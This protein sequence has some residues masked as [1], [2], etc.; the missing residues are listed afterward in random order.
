MAYRPGPYIVQDRIDNTSPKSISGHLLLRGEDQPVHLELTG[1]CMPDLRGCTV[2]FEPGEIAKEQ[3][4]RRE[5]TEEE[6]LPTFTEEGF[7]FRQVGTT[8]AITADCWIKVPEVPVEEA[9]KGDGPPGDFPF[10]WHRRF[11]MEWYSQNGRVVLELPDP[12]LAF[13]EGED[14]WDP[15]ENPPPDQDAESQLN[16]TGPT[17]FTVKPDSIEE[18]DTERNSSGDPEENAPLHDEDLDKYIRRLVGNPDRTAFLNEPEDSMEETR[19][20]D[21]LIEEGEGKPFCTLLEEPDRLPEPDRLSEDAARRL[22]KAMLVEMAFHNVC[23]H[24][25]KHYS[26]HDTYRLMVEELLTEQFY[27]SQLQ[28]TGWTTNY[29][30][31]EFCEKCQQ[32]VQEEFEEISDAGSDNEEL[33]SGARQQLERELNR[34]ESL[35]DHTPE[36]PDPVHDKRSGVERILLLVPV[37]LRRLDEDLLAGNIRPADD[38]HKGCRMA[39]KACTCS[40]TGILC[41]PPSKRSNRRFRLRRSCGI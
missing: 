21:Y 17:I 18:V 12:R 19:M 7:A 34:L 11:Y 36:E 35:F 6:E 24:I 33:I 28:G 32:E 16:P 13:L 39:S 8:G 38:L 5:G 27:Y 40:T 29:M 1:D 23:V 10:E 25:C 4:E 9:M 26:Y 30:T 20:M 41:P 31:A 15:D 3:L 14:N 22:V 2:R 37:T